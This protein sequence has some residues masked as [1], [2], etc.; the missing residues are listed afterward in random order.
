MRLRG[1]HSHR[2]L[3]LFTFPC[4][5]FPIGMYHVHS[6]HFLGERSRS[7][8]CLCTLRWSDPK[9]ITKT[10][11]VRSALV[12]D[13]CTICH[14]TPSTTHCRPDD[15]PDNPLRGAAALNV[16]R[17]TESSLNLLSLV[18]SGYAQT[19]EIDYLEWSKRRESTPSGPGMIVCKH[20]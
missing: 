8:H 1:L 12:P 4:C 10:P 14:A 15:R 13:L 18:V 2:H 11:L 6:S 7:H 20:H 9:P 17:G 16:T 3:V 19:N 5:P